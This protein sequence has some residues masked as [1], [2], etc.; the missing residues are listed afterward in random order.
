[1]NSILYCIFPQK[2]KN[3]TSKVFLVEFFFVSCLAHLFSRIATAILANSWKGRRR[4]N[5]RGKPWENQVANVSWEMFSDISFSRLKRN[6]PPFCLGGSWESELISRHNH[7]L[8]HI[9]CFAICTFCAKQ[10]NNQ[11]TLGKPLKPY[12]VITP[13]FHSQEGMNS[14]HHQA[15]KRPLANPGDCWERRWTGPNSCRL[16]VEIASTEPE[17]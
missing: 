12:L 13:I 5:C 16:V 14:S 15:I 7:I 17:F 2:E 11:K 10:N 4:K 6:R 9:R 8:F 1:M 3:T